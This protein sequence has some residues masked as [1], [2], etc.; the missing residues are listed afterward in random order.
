MFLPLYKADSTDWPQEI[1]A[2]LDGFFADVDDFCPDPALRAAVAGIDEGELRIR[3]GLALE[4][5]RDLAGSGDGWL[6]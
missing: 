1:F 6:P 3:A 2:V 4:R 5:L